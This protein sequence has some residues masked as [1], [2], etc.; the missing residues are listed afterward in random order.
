[1]NSKWTFPH[2]R[3]NWTVN[4]LHRVP[5]CYKLTDQFDHNKSFTHPKSGKG[6]KQ[7]ATKIL[8]IKH[9]KLLC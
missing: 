8:N 1:M 4:I 9:I 2:N 6:I 7:L 5:S 3:G